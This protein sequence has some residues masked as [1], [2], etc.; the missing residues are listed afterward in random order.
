M[1]K[2]KILTLILLLI[3]AVGGFFTFR[4]Y[5]VFFFETTTFE[6]ES[7]YVFLPRGADV[8]QVVESLTP[9]IQ[10]WAFLSPMLNC[11]ILLIFR[12]L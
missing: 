10:G 1:Y 12:E 11:K 8:S 6:N 3:T 9:L 2:R 7:A 4:F 5:Q